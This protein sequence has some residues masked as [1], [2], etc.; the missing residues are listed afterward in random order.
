MC[1]V[2]ACVCISVCVGTSRRIAVSVS[3]MRTCRFVLGQMMDDSLGR[4]TLMSSN[5]DKVAARRAIQEAQAER[6]RQRRE[7]EA[8]LEQLAVQVGASL[9]SGRRALAE[10]EIA[11][12]RAL[13]VMVGE[14]GLGVREIQ[15][16]CAVELAAREIGRL[17]RAA[18]EADELAGDGEEDS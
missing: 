3:S 16:W 14:F 15:E 7:R 18:G 9:A 17:R 4:T 2:C 1:E 6:V 11:A 5:K 12:G 10:A 13:N 8:Q